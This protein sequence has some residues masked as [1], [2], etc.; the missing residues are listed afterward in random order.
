[1]EANQSN[2]NSA[3]NSTLT[4]QLNPYY[5][6]ILDLWKQL[7]LEHT[8]LFDITCEEYSLMLS[9]D[10]DALETLIIKKENIIKSIQDLDNLRKHI[11][12]KINEVLAS[13]STGTGTREIQSVTDLINIF[14]QYEKNRGENF[15]SRYNQL[16]KS[17]IEKIQAQN[18]KNQI[19]LNKAIISIKEMRAGLLGKKSYNTYNS[20]GVTNS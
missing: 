20:M 8:N 12:N 6:D 11:I 9:S 5:F 7:C 4:N 15:L 1:M 19:F 10:V 18:K 17:I 2:S 13:S 16:L 3:S 14:H